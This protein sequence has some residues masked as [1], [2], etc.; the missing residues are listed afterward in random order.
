MG[1]T[2]P[3]TFD[4]VLVGAGKGFEGHP[5]MGVEATANI[6]PHD[7]GMAPMFGDSIRLE[8]DAEFS[9]TS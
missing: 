5:R 1:K 9:K 8:I 2:V 7:F 3:L 6:N 4:V